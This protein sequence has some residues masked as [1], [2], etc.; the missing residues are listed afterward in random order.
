MRWL[1]QGSTCWGRRDHSTVIDPTLTLSVAVVLPMAAA[2]V[3]IPHQALST[4]PIQKRGRRLHFGLPNLSGHQ[5]RGLLGDA[6][7]GGLIVGI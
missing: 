1:V 3:W 5:F 4:T 2:K 6:L 7:E